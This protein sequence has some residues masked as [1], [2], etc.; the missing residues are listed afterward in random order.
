MRYETL[1][2]VLVGL[3]GGFLY[4]DRKYSSKHDGS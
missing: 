3:I 4:Q 1:L 2:V